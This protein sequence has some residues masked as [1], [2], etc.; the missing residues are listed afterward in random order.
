MTTP[1]AYAYID[2]FDGVSLNTLNIRPQQCQLKSARAARIVTTVNGIAINIDGTKRSPARYPID[3][4]LDVIFTGSNPG[5]GVAMDNTMQTLATRHGKQGALRIRVPGGGRT[6][7]AQ[8]VL[9]WIEI[10]ADGIMTD[11]GV[12]WSIVALHFS[13]LEGWT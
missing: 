6:Y 12:S 1:I 11:T 10:T 13:Q 8:A 3:Q 4:R 2:Q 7:T 9:D 5:D